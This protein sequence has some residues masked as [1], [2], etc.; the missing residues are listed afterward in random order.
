VSREELERF[1]TAEG[2]TAVDR[3]F[4]EAEQDS[5]DF[6]VAEALD[7]NLYQALTEYDR[8]ATLSRW[9]S[10]RFTGPRTEG[11]L[12]EQAVEDVLSALRREISGASSTKSTDLLRLDLVGFSRGSAILHLVPAT[13]PGSDFYEN[14]N[15]EFQ[16]A[17]PIAQDQLDDALTV[18]TELHSAAEQQGDVQRFS[19][20]ET[21][22]RGFMALADALDKH[23]LDMGIM[24]R[25]RTGRHLSA[26]LTSRGRQH[27]RRYLERSETSDII[28]ITG[29]V[30]ELKIS[31]SFDVKVS[32]ATNSTRYTIT[33]GSEESLLSL[34]LEL[35]VIVSVRVR[36]HI[37]RNKVGIV[38]G[39]R[40]EYLNMV[41][42]GE[43]LV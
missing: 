1:L 14:D 23:D 22:L 16:E 11:R 30:V 5:N 42:A 39:Y 6:D 35:G 18:V 36:R 8:N 32:P 15:K 17:L 41:T 19:G 2:R 38:F 21:L 13:I 28:V 4:N 40:Y 20:Q 9:L 31:G 12:A 25:S 26:D 37:E 33:T 43:P 3:L 7:R 24:W 10:L 29:R 34:H 27:V